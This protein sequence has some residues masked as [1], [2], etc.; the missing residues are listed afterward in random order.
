MRWVLI[1]AGFALVLLAR[2]WEQVAW[3]DVTLFVVIGLA[4]AAVLGAYQQAQE[5]SEDVV[6][7]T[8]AFNVEAEKAIAAVQLPR[9]SSIIVLAVEPDKADTGLVLTYASTRYQATLC[10]ALARGPV[11]R[12]IAITVERG[13][14]EANAAA[15]ASDLRGA[16]TVY[17]LPGPKR[18]E[19]K[20]DAGAKDEKAKGPARKA[21]S[22]KPLPAGCPKKPAQEPVASKPTPCNVSPSRGRA[23]DPVPSKK[24]PPEH[25]QCPAPSDG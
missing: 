1:A 12:D 4:A 25:R 17:L 5:A 19:A 14:D 6:A 21:G 7:E 11:A 8:T 23:P 18:A 3:A 15:F 9:A 13:D 20:V 22:E 16:E 10:H 24:P 2:R